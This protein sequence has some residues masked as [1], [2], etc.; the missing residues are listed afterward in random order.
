M[1]KERENVRNKLHSWEN[2]K[3]FTAS[4]PLKI[5]LPPGSSIVFTLLT[6][7][8]KRRK[9][10]LSWK[11]KQWLT[12]GCAHKK[13]KKLLRSLC[14][15]SFSTSHRRPKAHC[16]RQEKIW[17]RVKTLRKWGPNKNLWYLEKKLTCKAHWEAILCITCSQYLDLS[18]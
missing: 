16:K 6:S 2:E 7:R 15:K 1:Q 4:K 18:I 5:F 14:I 10:E 9:L 13:R 17:C 8:R 11:K 12:K 3:Y